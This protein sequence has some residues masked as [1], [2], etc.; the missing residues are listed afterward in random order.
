MPRQTGIESWSHFL[1][2]SRRFDGRLINDDSRADS[3]RVSVSDHARMVYVVNV[4]IRGEAM[5]EILEVDQHDGRLLETFEKL[6]KVATLQSKGRANAKVRQGQGQCFAWRGHV[7][8]CRASR[9]RLLAATRVARNVG[10]NSMKW[11]SQKRRP[12]ATSHESSKHSKP[13]REKLSARQH[14][15]IRDTAQRRHG[16]S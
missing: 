8:T 7:S 3:G 16:S 14:T 13:H 1:P 6:S 10:S 15:I 5:L 4:T 2:S 12:L 9:R 11:V